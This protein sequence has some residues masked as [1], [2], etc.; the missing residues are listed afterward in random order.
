M[1]LKKVILIDFCVVF[2]YIIYRAD[3]VQ[4]R[5]QQV[6]TRSPK[7]CVFVCVFFLLKFTVSPLYRFLH[8]FQH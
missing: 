2:I 3:E 4:A 5:D 7:K 8:L 1:T 6:A